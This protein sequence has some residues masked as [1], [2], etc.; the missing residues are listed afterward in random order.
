MTITSLHRKYRPET[1][2]EVIG[3][4]QIVT[5][6]KGM[7]SSKKYPNAIMF[8]GATSAGKTTLARAL[9]S[10][11]NGVDSFD[12]LGNDYLEVNCSDKRTIDDVRTIVER[13]R[14]KPQRVKR[15]IVL[16]EVQGLI[17]N[18]A[19]AAALL[20]PLEEPTSSTLWI[21]CTMDPSKFTTGNGRAIANRCT[22]FVLER[23]EKEA[24][25]KQAIRI[26]KAE[27]MAYARDL[28]DD[29]VEYSNG[30][31]RSLA[32][33]IEGVQQY[34]S[35]LTK[36]PKRLKPEAISSVLKGGVTRDEELVVKVLTGIY[37]AKFAQAQAALL[38]VTDGVRF[39]NLLLQG[40]AFLMNLQ[41]IG[42]HPKIWWT[43]TNRELHQATKSLKITLGALAATNE[44]LVKAKA[45][46]N[47][48]T[49]TAEEALSAYI[50]R[51][52][53]DLFSVNK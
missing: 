48:F 3:H 19:A 2:D 4:E 7:V 14:Y 1:L 33:I 40:N 44:N 29:I 11:I 43:P 31:M 37:T 25:R 35:G 52:I 17:S 23:H 46:I 45:L 22:Q 36:K 47:N 6:L 5:R 34:Y 30:E 28:I 53:K 38:D 18:S 21:L 39:I 16:D 32:N 9:A 51:T 41:V 12:K 20:K 42:K 10:G 13:A 26:L 8:A 49:V 50:Y 27:R 15:I 24:L